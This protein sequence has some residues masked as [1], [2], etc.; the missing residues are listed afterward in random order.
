MPHSRVRPDNQPAASS[1]QAP[2]TG[3]IHIPRT[4]TSARTPPTCC[5]KTWTGLEELSS[6][7]IG[8]P[9]WNKAC[10]VSVS[11]KRMESNRHQ[12]KDSDPAEGPRTTPP[13]RDASTP[14]IEPEEPEGR[15]S[16]GV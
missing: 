1:A 8:E 3:V 2:Y 13:G 5:S 11:R 14:Q 4:V 12:P 9:R 10:V 15:A 16:P 7:E 6:S